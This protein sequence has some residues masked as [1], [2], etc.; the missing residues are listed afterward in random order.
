MR[1]SKP[2][3]NYTD[4]RNQT[5]NGLKSILAKLMIFNIILAPVWYVLSSIEPDIVMIPASCLMFGLI[6]Y[7]ALSLEIHPG[8]PKDVPASNI[9]NTDH[10]N[11]KILTDNHAIGADGELY[12]VKRHE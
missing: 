1:K 11:V 7:N 12:E 8:K 4:R 5:V 9:H 3:H 2:E 10:E 6:L